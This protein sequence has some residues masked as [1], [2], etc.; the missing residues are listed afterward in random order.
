[1]Q[2]R[3]R[4]RFRWLAWLCLSLML[5]TAVAEST[6]NHPNQT[7]SSSCSICVVA[8]ST[9]P[10]ASCNYARPVFVA[11]SQLQRKSYREGLAQRL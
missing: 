10:T 7:E 11:I 1:M 3:L 9:T 2:E 5:W 8:H 4:F 6:H